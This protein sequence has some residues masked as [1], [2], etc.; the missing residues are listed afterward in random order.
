MEERRIKETINGAN[1][2]D[3]RLISSSPS[4]T[5]KPLT[6]IVGD[7][8]AHG[9]CYY[10]EKADLAWQNKDFETI[11]D[12]FNEA[13]QK[14]LSSNIGSEYY[15]FVDAFAHL[16]DMEKA[17]AETEKW[18]STTSPA[19]KLGYCSLWKKIATEFP[20]ET[21]PQQ[22]IEKLECK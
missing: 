15:P 3:L 13:D 17:K 19:A 20:E 8:P 22:V 4:E 16:G 9:W 1:L 11:I 10:F 12:L 21:T 2:T 6:R 18:I 5:G 7:E 14:G